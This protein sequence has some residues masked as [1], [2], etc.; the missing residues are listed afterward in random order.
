MRSKQVACFILQQ[1]TPDVKEPTKQHKW[2]KR[3]A[4]AVAAVVL[5]PVVLFFIVAGLL[6]V[7]AIQNYVVDRVAESLSDSTDLAF[8]VERVRLGFP[9]D[10]TVHNVQA[11][12][13][14]DSVLRA[15]EL[16]LSV[17]FWPLLSGQANV[18]GI[19][20]HNAGVNTRGLIA[21]TQIIGTVGDFR[22][23]LHGLNWKTNN[24]HVRSGALSN[25]DVTVLLCDTAAADTTKGAPWTIDVDR[26]SI[27]RTKARLTL[28]SDSLHLY[29]ELGEAEASGIHL[30]TGAPLYSVERL[31]LEASAIYY[32][33]EYRQR[34]SPLPAPT[35]VE[36]HAG[37]N[38]D[39]FHIDSLETR[40]RSF[41]Y[42]ADGRLSLNVE[43]LSFHE[44]VSGLRLSE[45]TASVELNDERLRVP[46]L[47][48][49]TPHSVLSSDISLP[50]KA[51]D[52][53][54]LGST[55]MHVVLNAEVGHQ[56]VRIIGQG[57]VP[58]EILRNYPRY[59]VHLD[60]L[61]QGNV[62]QLDVS[63]L[64]LTTPYSRIVG[65]LS[66]RPKAFETNRRYTSATDGLSFDMQAR[67][68][69]QDVAAFGKP[70]MPAELFKAYPRYAVQLAARGGLN[71]RRMNL[72]SFKLQTPSSHISGSGN[73][74]F[75][76]FSSRS[77]ADAFKFNL[78]AHLSAADVK[79]FAHPFLT[80]DVERM[81]PPYALDVAGGVAGNANII[82][83]QALTLRTPYSS[84]RADGSINMAA[85][86]GGARGEAL[87]LKLD[88]RIG[89]Q[90]LMHYGGPYLTNDIKS[91]L[92][93]TA[94]A[95]STHI[96]GNLNSLTLRGTS[97]AI[98]GIARISGD[99]SLADI[100]AGR[101][102]GTMDIDVHGQNLG[103]LN[104]FI[105]ADLRNTL[106]IPSDLSARGKV[107]FSGDDYACDLII[108]Q[109]GGSAKVRAQVNLRTE[110]YEAYVN[111]DCFPVQHFLPHEDMRDFTGEINANG[112][113]FDV[114]SPGAT[115]NADTRIDAFSYTGYDLSGLS[116]NAK[117]QGGD[118]AAQFEASNSLLQGNGWLN[119]TFSNGISARLNAQ[120][121][122][123]DLTQLLQTP[124]TI[125]AG[126]NIDLTLT[127]SNDFSTLN[128]DG[129]L[130]SI[131]FSSKDYGFMPQDFLFGLSTTPDT[132]TAH[133]NSGD[134]CLRYG[135]KGEL[136]RA[137]EQLSKTMEVID[138]QIVERRFVEKEIRPYLPVL[139]LHFSAG[140]DNPIYTFIE[141]QGYGYDYIALDLSTNPRDGLSGL[142]EGTE[143]KK[144]KLVFDT[145]YAKLNS[146]PDGLAMDALVHNFKK[147]NPN[148]FK[149][150][151]KGYLEE[152][153]GGL[154]ACFKDEHGQ[155]GM[156]F[157]VRAT[158]PDDGIRLHLYPKQSILAYRTF[159]VN[160]DNYIFYGP[161]NNKIGADLDLLADDGT[162]L[163]LSGEPS[164]SL[165]DI[166]LSLSNVNLRE[167]SASVPYMPSMGG[168]LTGDIHYND[169]HEQVSAMATVSL[170]DFEYEQA[171]MGTL[172]IDG[173][174]L[175]KEEGEH[176]ASAFISN[177]E[178]EVLA[179]EGTYNERS[180]AFLADGNLMQ[181][182]LRYLNG[183]LSGTDVMMRGMSTGDFTVSGTAATPVLNGSIAFDSAHVYS[184]VYGFDF[185]MDNRPVVLNNSK[186][187][188]DGYRLTSTGNT[189]LTVNGH[190][191][192]SNLSR[193]GVDLE[194]LARDFELI[195][196]KR[197]KESIVY[198]KLFTDF[199]G[200]L[201]GNTADGFAFNGRIDVLPRTDMTYILRDSPLT[202]ED[203]LQ[204]LVKF[205]NFADTTD[206]EE[207]E[208]EESG[209]FEMQLAVNIDENAHF[210][211]NLSENGNSFVDVKAGG[212]LTL[213]QTKEGDMRL[214]GRLVIGE[215]KMKY[216]LPII[217]LKTFDIE[218]DSYINFQGDAT[219]PALGLSA[220]ERIKAIVSE[221][222]QQRSVYFNVGLKVSQTLN[223]MGLEFTID[224]PE[225]LVIQNQLDAMSTEERSRVAV[226]M[227][228][229]GMYLTSDQ[230]SGS[231][232]KASNALNAF[233]QSEIQ[234]IAGQALKTVDLSVGVESGTSLSG[235]T[236]TDYSF[237]FAKRF[238]DDRISVIIGGRVS[239]GQDA[240]NSAE[241]FID[242]IAVEY[243]LDRNATRRL[244]IFYNRETQDPLEG[245]LTKAGVGL[246]LHKKSERLGD[247]F[248]F[249]RAKTKE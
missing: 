124:D 90:D 1:I 222:D 123:I 103:L 73:L 137:I 169:N 187:Q 139:D 99:L 146:S 247:L 86:S 117:S 44:R 33:A 42:D 152:E 191:D 172:N 82:R 56:D 131:H 71:S 200:T 164:D 65:Q 12:E 87:N 189:P 17:E 119:A 160:D 27:A 96:V 245:Q 248:I 199:D 231:G 176:Y 196:S 30:D 218:K 185:A 41:C 68:G 244:K 221:N 63:R 204:G 58:D 36:R 138:T 242:N 61:V 159:T 101:L 64:N 135:A 224:A 67:L 214:L 239:T 145:V 107:S 77:G 108:H 122:F 78:K 57:L 24:V 206:M 93:H 223:R 158:L 116:F 225:D 226:A 144:D 11:T 140:Q 98:P 23:D 227:L 170:Q 125:E 193:V 184:P 32:D 150:T 243:R 195:N 76:A 217:P 15:E 97:V 163:R 88:G 198:G 70:Y 132:T 216:E 115:L 194:M 201:R 19:H 28:P 9:L 171:Q 173:I 174:Y 53:E 66:V 237:Q 175:P 7:P 22:A 219:N 203:Q 182:P 186:M 10:L 202:V 52:A 80:S 113:L 235:G 3:I 74:A 155:T 48:L 188:F 232:F 249:K 209:N 100:A 89:Y 8:S 129:A 4:K 2:Q 153:A 151:L 134:F 215:G 112:R 69:W 13:R 72:S 84:M 118:V 136:L 178:Q 142:L 236:T 229:T 114:F 110:I 165:T 35:L 79:T 126:M 111:A 241:S 220:T 211:C 121:P 180:E 37:L 25:A 213:R 240:D 233:L 14:G 197:Q 210:L 60:G 18:S 21:N 51:L 162:G 5:L 26:V 205:V 141:T 147:R 31:D 166:T 143:L 238:W 29:A 207:P 192:M 161:A 148:R 34:F 45:L 246:V 102:H 38:F 127:G 168:F 50:W 181:F 234:N 55:S 106:T 59:Q 43:H 16:A 62:K 81:L 154:E 105:P 157:G 85:L 75:D 183:F 177:T 49:F 156:D 109:G 128:A 83:T 46:D 47:R 133:A 104:R 91:A 149:A 212:A 228:A 130:T 95:L 179:L 6:Y 92:P 208:E 20:L 94:I 54:A 167:L 40:L 230:A 120:L 190:V 39:H